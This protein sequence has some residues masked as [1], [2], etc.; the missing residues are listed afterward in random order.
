MAAASVQRINALLQRSSI[1]DHEEVIKACNAVLKKS[2]NDLDALH[3][4]TVALLKLD[5]YED[6][7]RVV[8]EGGDALKERVPLEWSYAFY[9]VGKLEDAIKLATASGTGRGGKHV[10]AQ[11]VRLKSLFLAYYLLPFKSG[12]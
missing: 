6:A 11:V 3:V 10:E 5:R 8:E 1:D 7:I 4:K 12:S 9:K 2:R